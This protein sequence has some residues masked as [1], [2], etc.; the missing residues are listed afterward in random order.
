MLISILFGSLC[1][2]WSGF[3]GSMPAGLMLNKI[4]GF[5]DEKV[6]FVVSL[7]CPFVLCPVFRENVRK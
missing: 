1:L 6:A 7:F 3:I 2:L 4:L 5:N